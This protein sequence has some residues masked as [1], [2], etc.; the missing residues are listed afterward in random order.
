MKK[1]NSS[2]IDF[3]LYATQVQTYAGFTGTMA[4]VVMFFT[5]LIITKFESFDILIKVPIAFLIISIFGFLYSTLLYANAAQEVSNHSGRE[6]LRAIF[7]GDIVSE[8][9]GVYLLVISVPLVIDVITADFFLRSVTIIASLLG[10]GL[11]Q[12]SH[13]S[14]VERHFQNN[15][16][17]ISP[18]IIAL[19]LLLFLA[20]IYRTYFVPLAIAF[21]LLLLVV[22][23]VASRQRHV[24]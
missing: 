10:L 5:G 15:H 19:G 3:S 23:Y 14:I 8:Y 7:F 11:Y 12:F 1:K 18:F 9:L 13:F 22:S 4:A 17:Y 21:G 24:P 6:L 20:Q 2:E 16:R